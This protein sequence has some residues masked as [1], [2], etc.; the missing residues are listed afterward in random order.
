MHSP[1]SFFL[2][3]SVKLKG[4]LPHLQ[5]KHRNAALVVKHGKE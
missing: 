1:A 2:K 3:V 4:V 5:V